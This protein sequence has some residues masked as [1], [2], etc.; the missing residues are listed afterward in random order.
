MNTI[1]ISHANVD[2]SISIDG[3]TVSIS[4]DGVWVGRGRWNGAAIEDCAADLG[5]D[6]Y[7]ALDAA[8]A[9]LG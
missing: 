8:I 2:Y 5:D 3:E 1:E 7:D 4:A 6:V 9:R